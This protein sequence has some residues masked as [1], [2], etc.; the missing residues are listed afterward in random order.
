MKFPAKLGQA[1]LTLSA[2]FSFGIIMAGSLFVM[3][4]QIVTGNYSMSFCVL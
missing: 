2:L 1:L 4:N 3:G